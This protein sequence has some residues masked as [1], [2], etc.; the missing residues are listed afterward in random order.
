M[1]HHQYLVYYKSLVC[2]FTKQT[3][4]EWKKALLPVTEKQNE[5]GTMPVYCKGWGKKKGSKLKKQTN[6]NQ[7]YWFIK[8]NG[9]WSTDS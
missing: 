6:K 2:C 7:I 9:F 4:P 8:P 1:P 5:N 3:N